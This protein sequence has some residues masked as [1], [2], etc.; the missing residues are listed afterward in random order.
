MY[1]LYFKKKQQ[2]K[3]FIIHSFSLIS[4]YTPK[5]SN[6]NSS[7]HRTFCNSFNIQI[8]TITEGFLHVYAHTPA[9]TKSIFYTESK[10]SCRRE[11]LSSAV[12]SEAVLLPFHFKCLSSTAVTKFLCSNFFSAY[13]Y[14]S[15]YLPLLR[16]LNPISRKFQLLG[17]WFLRVAFFEFMILTS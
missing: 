5:S 13:V 14:A 7:T 8:L 17:N 11:K 6:L 3:T 2:Q 9:L 16:I 4:S 15:F 12:D 10:I 1:L